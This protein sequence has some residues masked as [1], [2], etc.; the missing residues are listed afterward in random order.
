M[1]R[2]RQHQAS[3]T[4]KLKLSE[5]LLAPLEEAGEDHIYIYICVTRDRDFANFKAR[6]LGYNNCGRVLTS[7]SACKNRKLHSRSSALAQH[8]EQS[9]DTWT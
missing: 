1:S 3:L 9:C 8:H 4:D 7:Y 6:H 2:V 5:G